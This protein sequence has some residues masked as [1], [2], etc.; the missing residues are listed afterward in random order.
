M[1]KRA[2]WR[3]V[4]CVD[5][6]YRRT[7]QARHWNHQG[8][9][10][11]FYLYTWSMHRYAIRIQYHGRFQWADTGQTPVVLF[12]LFEWCFQRNEFGLLLF[13]PMHQ[14]VLEIAQARELENYK[15]NYEQL[16][17]KMKIFHKQFL[18]RYHFCDSLVI[19]ILH[20]GGKLPDN[21]SRIHHIRCISQYRTW[22]ERSIMGAISS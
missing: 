21:R 10:C 1:R 15:L 14:W 2:S 18:Q 8:H 12:L 22:R 9:E 11:R 5:A 3:C 7:Q 4:G 17:R 13:L 20:R 19:E 6:I 16:Q